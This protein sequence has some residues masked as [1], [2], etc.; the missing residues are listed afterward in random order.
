D[1]ITGLYDVRKF[2]TGQSVICWDSLVFVSRSESSA[3]I[4][5]RLVLRKVPYVIPANCD[6]SLTIKLFPMLC[7]SARRNKPNTVVRPFWVLDFLQLQQFKQSLLLLWRYSKIRT[8]RRTKNRKISQP[9]I[10]NNHIARQCGRDLADN[11]QWY[12]KLSARELF[13]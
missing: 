12:A 5:D 10:L 11:P 2:K 3:G 4:V 6:D 1:K 9:A 8:L 7:A 13:A